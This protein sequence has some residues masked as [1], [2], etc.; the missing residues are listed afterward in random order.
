MSPAGHQ[1]RPFEAVSAGDPLRL[2][3][4]DGLVAT[5]ATACRAEFPHL[6]AGSK[7]AFLPVGHRD[8]LQADENFLNNHIKAGHA[9]LAQ[10]GRV[11]RVEP[12][13][14]HESCRCRR[15]ILP[16]PPVL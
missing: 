14:A 13:R 8:S 9:T 3:Q 1:T 5:T 10:L 4:R 12:F 7:L 11:R 16:A 2:K 15:L 6:L